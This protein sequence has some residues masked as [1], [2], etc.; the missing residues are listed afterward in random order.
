MSGTFSSF[1]TALSALRYNRVAMDVASGN[2]ANAGTEGYAR[3]Q[4]IGQATGAPAVP[5]MWS[6]W[7]VN[8]GDGV[9]PG[10]IKRMVDPL[11]DARARL[12]HAASGFLDTRVAS[13]NRFE[14]ALAEPGE[15]GVA[16]ALAAYQAGWHDVANNPGDPAARAQLIARAETLRGAIVS[17]DRAVRT[18]WADQRSRLTA[19]AEEVEQ[20]AKE[21]AKVNDGLRSAY[22]AG[23]DAG[24]LL[25]QR[26]LLTMRL[27]E[28]T[29]SKITI[30]AD[31]TVDVTVQGQPLVS[32]NVS[33]PVTVTGATEL[34]DPPGAPVEFRVGNAALTLT[35]GEVGGIQS[36]MNTDLPNYLAKLDAFVGQLVS[37]T[38]TQHA[39]GNDADGNP[40][41]AFFSG[42]TAATLAVA[43]TD[44]SDVAAGDPSKG[45]LDGSNASKLAGLDM[46]GRS[47][48]ELITSTGVLI[49]SANR[50][51]A[52]Q[53]VLVSQVDASREALSGI[54][55][56]EEMV[57]LL[58]AQRGYEGASR[59][60]TTIDSVLDTLIN[61]T[62]LLR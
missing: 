46:G 8:A 32:G 6:R 5:A 36:V 35:A 17:Q 55:I 62:G 50:G 33:T 57:N 15:N 18:E 30:K 20:V 49:S 25:D 39:L 24:V 4:V 3:R 43:I 2:V 47:Y 41:G 38:N 9:Q 44:P 19:A 14:T 22:V 58:A 48:R 21:L 7:D 11:L 12:E 51:A 1:N 16:A 13:L 45:A 28:L 59:V 56:D 34:T 60:L 61:R 54:S 37:D 27:S 10:G 26:D 52:N 40:G 42:T 53:A 31:T 29:G 23:T